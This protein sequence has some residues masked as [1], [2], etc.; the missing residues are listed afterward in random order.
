M[1][2]KFIAV[3]YASDRRSA[4]VRTF[5]P[6]RNVYLIEN[7]S[8]VVD[9]TNERS[10]L[11]RPSV[12]PIVILISG[13]T[14]LKMTPLILQTVLCS[15]SEQRWRPQSRKA[16]TARECTVC[17]TLTTCFRVHRQSGNCKTR[18][19]ASTSSRTL[20]KKKRRSRRSSRKLREDIRRVASRTSLSL[21]TKLP[22]PLTHRPGRRVCECSHKC[23]LQQTPRTARHENVAS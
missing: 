10:T 23:V 13:S 6:V 7:H 11:L 19:R 5:D 2:T 8:R 22:L 14:I 21:H 3:I 18:R 9:E 17:R 1:G 4:H 12:T 20:P 15:V 16:L